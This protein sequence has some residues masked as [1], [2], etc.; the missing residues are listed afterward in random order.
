[1]P[2][3]AADSE[4]NVYV[5]WDSYRT[6]NYDIFLRRIASD[7]SMGPIQQ[8]TKSVRMQSHVSVAV[9]GAGR[10]WLAW[11]ESGANWGKDYARH[12]TWRGKT[13]YA[14]RPPRVA[15]WLKHQ[16]G[17]PRGRSTWT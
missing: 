8:V 2:D 9:D 1:M 7:G 13:L 12:G 4:G 6:V 3:A 15:A 14:N 11:G 5:A 17:L 16:V 10:V